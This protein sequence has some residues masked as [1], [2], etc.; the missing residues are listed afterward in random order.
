MG[1]VGRSSVKRAISGLRV[2]S[3]L[4]FSVQIFGLSK[5]ART[6]LKG[7]KLKD[8]DIGSLTPINL[9]W[10]VLESPKIWT[11]KW[12]CECTLRHQQVHTEDNSYHCEQC[13]KKASW[14]R[15]EDCFTYTLILITLLNSS[16]FGS[17]QA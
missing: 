10:T 15:L 12:R 5:I 16:S 7:V 13:R 14:L 6:K 2:R 11:K 4:H 1:S 8:L 17:K 3:H 9:V